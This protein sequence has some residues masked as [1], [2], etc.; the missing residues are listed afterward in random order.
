[1]AGPEIDAPKVDPR[2][3]LVRL[4]SDVNRT[5][6]GGIRWEYPKADRV[7][8]AI[9]MQEK[10][11]VWGVGVLDDI[12]LAMMESVGVEEAIRSLDKVD[13]YALTAVK[14]LV[15]AMGGAIDG[16]EDGAAKE[17]KGALIAH[18][19]IVDKARG[20]LLNVAAEKELIALERS[21]LT[22]GH[23]VE[24]TDDGSRDGQGVEWEFDASYEAIQDWAQ[25]MARANLILKET[26][27]QLR[28]L[29]GDEAVQSA[30]DFFNLV[31]LTPDAAVTAGEK[32]G[33]DRGSAICENRREIHY[34]IAAEARGLEALA[35]Y[36]GAVV[37]DKSDVGSMESLLTKN[38]DPKPSN[39]ELF[40]LVKPPMVDAGVT[41]AMR[42]MVEA[43]TIETVKERVRIQTVDG[44][45]LDVEVD[46][47]VYK[48][49]YIEK[50]RKYKL[51]KE[52]K[53]DSTDPLERVG[54]PISP[55]RH[56]Q[57]PDK[58]MQWLE[59][60]RRLIRDELKEKGCK[61]PAA[62]A[63]ST[64]AL[65]MAYH[66]FLFLSSRASV[67]RK[68]DG[69]PL[70]VLRIIDGKAMVDHRGQVVYETESAGPGTWS[71][72]FDDVEEKLMRTRDRFVKEGKAGHSAPTALAIYATPTRFFTPLFER[73]KIGG[74]P[75]LEALRTG[76]ATVGECFGLMV[77]NERAAQALGGYRAIGALKAFSEVPMASVERTMDGSRV[78]PKFIDA[79]EDYFK[80]LNKA[81]RMIFKDENGKLEYWK[82][83]VVQANVVSL[84]IR[85]AR[86][87]TSLEGGGM[88][89]K[90]KLGVEEVLGLNNMF[91]NAW[92]TIEEKLVVEAPEM[93]SVVFRLGKAMAMS[94]TKDMRD[95]TF[96]G[97]ATK[98]VEVG[99]RVGML[100]FEDVTEEMKLELDIDPQNEPR[101]RF[102]MLVDHGPRGL[103]FDSTS[104][105][106]ERK[107]V[108]TTLWDEVV[109]AAPGKK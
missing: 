17:E 88:Q 69:T 46:V 102:N 66:E 14:G 4:D 12:L 92:N 60:M 75:M 95:P 98:S 24:E 86:R 109:A 78:D 57:T 10:D 1:M 104:Q 105:I 72:W 26:E 85:Y 65:A 47:P 5:Q 6:R 77:E 91:D 93:R 9:E 35:D 84:I 51:W 30:R 31:G 61:K 37:K 80:G 33:E 90:E 36:I 89:A 28:T 62:M 79:V 15:G 21:L 74:L 58:R 63:R 45:T 52:G 103:A 73:S 100:L 40:A 32:V 56:K 20:Q 81:M 87:Q 39:T 54:E 83:A 38:W 25:R 70:Q 41:A 43:V 106:K 27:N 44:R 67:R 7:L 68:L 42:E 97:D 64:L 19:Q 34:W 108:V 55:Y 96:P 50:L 82:M 8:D 49:E 94:K 53:P 48:P 22:R 99:D 13:F 71:A 16:L 101:G 2:E 23:V 18:E 11:N 107:A 76:K 29:E 59:G 3:E